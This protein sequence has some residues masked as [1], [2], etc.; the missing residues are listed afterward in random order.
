MLIIKLTVLGIIFHLIYSGVMLKTRRQ[1]ELCKHE[2]VRLNNVLIYTQQTLRTNTMNSLN[3][4]RLMI[5][6]G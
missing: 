4:A 1:A 6:K 5:I 3:L 2:Q